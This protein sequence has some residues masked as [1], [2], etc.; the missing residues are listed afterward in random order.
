MATW[1][2]VSILNLHYKYLPFSFYFIT[3]AQTKYKYTSSFT[4]PIFTF[5]MFKFYRYLTYT[6]YKSGKGMIK[7][8]LLSYI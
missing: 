4:K 2:K 8:Y 7:N 1:E 3:R 6:K 5:G